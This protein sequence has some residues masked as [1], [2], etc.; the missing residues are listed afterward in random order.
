[1]LPEAAEDLPVSAAGHGGLRDDVR[2]D[3]VV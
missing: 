2:G 3:G 1:M